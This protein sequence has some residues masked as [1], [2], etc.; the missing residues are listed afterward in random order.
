MLIFRFLS[1]FFTKP[2]PTMYLSDYEG[3]MVVSGAFP[4]FRLK[5]ESVKFSMGDFPFLIF[6]F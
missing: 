5:I 6:N 1:K 3:E 2:A 4:V